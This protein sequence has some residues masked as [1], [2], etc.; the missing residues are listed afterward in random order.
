VVAEA[1]RIEWLEC[2]AGGGDG[3]WQTGEKRRA[4]GCQREEG[5]DGGPL[6]V[7]EH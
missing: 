3:G 6:T 5:G 7:T 4:E 1:P 2:V